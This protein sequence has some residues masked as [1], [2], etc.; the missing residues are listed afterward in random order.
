[1]L[2]AYIDAQ[3]G[4]QINFKLSYLTN[5]TEVVEMQALRVGGYTLPNEQNFFPWFGEPTSQMFDQQFTY[6][7]LKKAS[8]TLN[9]QDFET[10][11]KKMKNN[12]VFAEFTNGQ[13]V[14]VN[15]TKL[16]FTPNKPD[17]VEFLNR[18]T[19]GF[20]N[21]TEAEYLY[22]KDSI[23]MNAF[24]LPKAIQQNI[25][26]KLMLWKDTPEGS[27]IIT[28]TAMKDWTDKEV[29]LYTNVDWPLQLE[30]GDTVGLFFHAK[31]D[32]N[33]VKMISFVQEWTGE[34][35]VG[36][37]VRH[38]ISIQMEPQLSQKQ[39]NTLVKKA[40]GEAK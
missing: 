11:R 31:E 7:Y 32:A 13:T 19:Q 3:M 5:K 4:E 1:V 37:P 6:Q 22:I 12:T 35:A 18:G 25:D 16:N 29:P 2:D 14:P 24:E 20:N 21:N 8:F 9:E 10:L 27:S 23:K 40:R 38:D 15:I 33:E 26:I 34:N 17:D 39:V 30:V 28:E 36:K